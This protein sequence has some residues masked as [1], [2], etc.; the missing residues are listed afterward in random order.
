MKF[1]SNNFFIILF[2]YILKF[3]FL[4]IKLFKSRF[5]IIKKFVKK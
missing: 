5:N 2:I 3:F 1:L 4:E